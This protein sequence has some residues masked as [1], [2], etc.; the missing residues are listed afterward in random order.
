MKKSTAMKKNIALV[1]VFTVLIIAFSGCA[2]NNTP[3]DNETEPNT[4]VINETN[5]SNANTGSSELKA[6]SD[7][8]VSEISTLTTLPAGFNH[9]AT[10]PISVDQI[11]ADYEAEN[12]SG[13]VGGSEGLY[14]ANGSDFYVD[15]I[16]LENKEAA[17]NFISVYKASFPPL[18]EGSSR[19]TEESFN[20]HS[21]TLIT[22]YITAGGKT[23]PRYSYIWNNENFVIAVF[24]NTDDASLVKQLAVAVEY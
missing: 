16:E 5:I 7:E 19:F 15:V 4:P 8:N 17:E 23:V 1:L 10:L 12:V 13:I 21:A 3:E 2:D 11:K 20:G 22:D 14:K 24:G 6:I 18:Q 9:T